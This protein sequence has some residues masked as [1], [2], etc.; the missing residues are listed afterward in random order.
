M[1]TTAPRAA[2]NTPCDRRRSAGFASPT[3]GARAT[4]SQARRVAVRRRAAKSS[5]RRFASAGEAPAVET[6]M[7]IGPSRWTA[8][9]INEQRAGSS[10]TLQNSR[11][12]SAS[13]AISPCR[14]EVI[15]GDDHEP[16]LVEVGDL[17]VALD[18]LDV[19]LEQAR[20]RTWARPASPRR[21]PPAATCVFS[22]AIG[23]PPTTSTLRAS[24]S[25]HAMKANGS[26]VRSTSAPA[27]VMRPRSR[28]ARPGGRGGSSGRDLPRSAR[29]E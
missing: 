16:P 9:R 11:R 14:L 7:V 3:D 28:R 29:R 24:S 23:P 13:I 22:S 12:R 1:R 19:Q 10:T 4:A 17:E 20:Q 18:P 8:G 27:S 26:V 5:R 2:R 15:G 25:R 6:A 21:R